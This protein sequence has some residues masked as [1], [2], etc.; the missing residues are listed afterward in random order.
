ML[1]RILICLTAV[2]TSAHAAT[3]VINEVMYHPSDDFDALQYVELFNCS[4]KE[5]DLSGWSFTHGPKY[6]FP[7]KSKIPAHG[8]LVICRNLD[9]FHKAYLGDIPALGNFSGKLNHKGEKIELVDPSKKVIES[10]KYSDHEPWPLGADG[11]SSSLERISPEAPADDPQSW[12]PSRPQGGRSAWGSPGRANT[13]FSAKLLPVVKDVKWNAIA[14]PGQPIDISA[15]ISGPSEIAQTA[16]EYTLFVNGKPNGNSTVPMQRSSTN[17]N[18]Y[19]ARI[20][21]LSEGTLLRFIIKAATKDSSSRLQPS[22]N[23]P[24]PA[25]SI[26]V[27]AAKNTGT[28]PTAIVLNTAVVPKSV[29]QFS[30]AAADNGDRGQSAFIFMAPSGK[31]EVRDFVQVR[32]RHGGWKVHFLKDELLDGMS[33]INLIF[34]GPSRWVL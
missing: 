10:F 30:P 3:V 17:G 8:F 7:D 33:A 9:A 12:A 1:N 13:A 5:V 2:L 24:R 15:N 28:I 20:G 11:Y 29:R 32:R 34:E 26:Y 21:A 6:T 23:E 18:V 14:T 22:P 27:T 4:D 25:Y 31:P 19:Q 16:V